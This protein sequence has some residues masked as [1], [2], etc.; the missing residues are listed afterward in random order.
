LGT[1]LCSACITVE[2][3]PA[4]PAPTPDA[5]VDSDAEPQAPNDG[6]VPKDATPNKT[7]CT[8]KIAGPRA[9]SNTRMVAA[10]GRV[11]SNIDR[12][13]AVD[14]AAATVALTLGKRTDT[15]VFEGFG[16]S[17]PATAKVT[18][19]E[20]SVVRKGADGRSTSTKDVI[21]QPFPS[22]GGR[23]EPSPNNW[24]TSYNTAVYGGPSETFGVSLSP[25][26]VNSNEFALAFAAEFNGPNS[27]DTLS[28]DGAA[29]RVFYCE[30][31]G[32][33]H[34]SPKGLRFRKDPLG[35]EVQ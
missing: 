6:G 11:W 22:L 1:A 16:F 13:M 18:G 4:A 32:A 25:T 8:N 2:Q 34:K 26:I 14:G 20:F 30:E 19:V 33:K 17:I 12:A 27:D 5:E 29:A 24:G 3:G 7:G 10:G 23:N 21:A 35:Y 15:L 28:V 9:P 31:P